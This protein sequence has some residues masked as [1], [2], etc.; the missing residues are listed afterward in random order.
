MSEKTPFSQR[1]ESLKAAFSRRYGTPP[2]VI[3]RAPG[4]VNL[5]GEH[6]DYNDGYVLPVAID[7]SVLLAASVRADRTVRLRALDFDAQVTFSLDDIHHAGRHRWSDYQ[8]GVATVLQER[9]FRLPGVDAAF[10]SDVPIGAGLSSSA[11]VE[12]SAAV[13]WQTVAGLDVS[14][15]ELALLCQRAENTFVGVNCGIMDQFISALGQ[16]GTA[17][18][19][20]CRTLDHRP[21]SIP[22]GFAVVIMDTAKQRGLTDSAYNTRRAECE[23]GV[24]LLRAHLP[25]IEALRDVSVPDFE[26][27]AGELPLNVRK[28]CRHVIGENQRVLDGIEALARGDATTF[29]RLMDESHRSLRDDYEVSCAEL[30]AM[31]E[32]AWRAPGV[33]GARM[34]GAGFGGCAVALVRAEYT[35]SFTD[36][37]AAAYQEATGLAPSLYVCTPEGGASVVH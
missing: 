12:V 15:P 26:Q 31:V 20:D 8:R 1:V 32:A 13:M 21:V 30:D 11:A 33:V 16:E 18:F 28:R 5:I 25:G 10:S 29:G 2:E 23:E 27:Y 22:E 36:Q 24:R 9:G 35:P 3:V 37:V 19:I 14:R 6:T 4:R 17:L 34:T 7:R